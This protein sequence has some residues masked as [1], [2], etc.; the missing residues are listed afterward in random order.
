MGGKTKAKS[1]EPEAAKTEDEMFLQRALELKDK[2]NVYFGQGEHVQALACYAQA[3]RVA[4]EGHPDRAMFHSN[5]AACYVK[6]H[7]YDEAIHECNQALSVSPGFSK[8]LLRRASAFEG[9]GDYQR[10]LADLRGLIEDASTAPNTKMEAETQMQKLDAMKNTTKKQRAKQRA[11]LQAQSQERSAMTS[12]YPPQGAPSAAYNQAMAAQQAAM[13]QRQKPAMQP[14]QLKVTLGSDTRTLQVPGTVQMSD[15]LTLVKRRFPEETGNLHLKYR[16]REGQLITVASRQDL[17]A[18]VATSVAA[19]AQAAAKAAAGPAGMGG[20]GLGKGLP[21]QPNTL[22]TVALELTR[23]ELEEVVEFDDWLLDFAELFREHLGIDA[24]GHVDLHNEG[25]EKCNAALEEAVGSDKAVPLFEQAAA[26]FQEVAAL[27]LLNWGNVHM[28]QA[29][30]LFESAAAEAKSAEGKDET[31]PVTPPVVSPEARAA[32]EEHYSQAEAKYVKALELKEDFYEAVIASGQQ[33]FERAKLLSS[34][35][36][37]DAKAKAKLEG[38]VEELFEA[39][40]AKLKSALTLIPEAP[41]EEEAAKKEGEAA[42]DP[43]AVAQPDVALVRSQVLVMWGNVLYEQSQV[44]AQQSKPWEKALDEAVAKFREAKCSEDDI[45]G[46]LA[47]H[48]GKKAQ[49]SVSLPPKKEP[50]AKG[51]K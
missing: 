3:L 28:C 47:S 8:A 50:G 29:R 24:D 22:P 14:L 17:L 35:T 34:A 36:G 40:Q 16:D 39:A 46:A 30:R 41:K 37:G 25:L 38:Q 21:P 15:L 11:A 19:Q 20:A 4:P 5:R 51:K 49:A 1:S 2:G 6:Q 23:E 44:R 42:A 43:A 45:S 48:A 10:S 33:L 31:K 13:A 26:K 7:S 18:A 32:A 27:A 9:K 12:R